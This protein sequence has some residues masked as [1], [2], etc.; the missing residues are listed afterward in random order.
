MKRQ[1]CRFLAIG[2]LSTVAYSVLFLVFREAMP[3]AASNAVALLV[4]ALANTEANRRV[5][6]AV[7]GSEGRL[8]DHAAGLGAFAIA[9]TIT[10]GSVLVLQGVAPGAPRIVE[11]SVLVASNVLATMV[12]FILLRTWI[13]RPSRRSILVP[14]RSGGAAR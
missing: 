14:T 5:T 12:R 7:R 4:T 1:L 9:L 13:D 3:A 10:S 11:L 6:F 2:V 8:R